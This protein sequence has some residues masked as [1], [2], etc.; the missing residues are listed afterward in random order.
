MTAQA[1]LPLNQRLGSRPEEPKLLWMVVLSL[2]L[3]GIAFGVFMGL[4]PT[5]SRNIYYSPVYSVDLVGLPPAGSSF[6]GSASKQTAGEQPK[7]T[8]TR[9]WKGPSALESQA[10]PQAQRAHPVLTIPAKEKELAPRRAEPE[11]RSAESGGAETPSG[12]TSGDSGASQGTSAPT[13]AADSS[14]QGVGSG[15]PGVPGG[16]PG[17]TGGG[18]MAD[19]RFR[20][21]YQLIYEKIYQAWTLPEYV[22]ERERS[23]EAIVVIK[24]QRD[25]KILS[26]VFETTSGNQ[27]FDISVMNAIK[28]ANPLPPLPDDFRDS[29]L[30]IGVRFIPQ[31]KGP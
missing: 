29:F 17:G 14:T 13:P 7:K 23:R 21:Y 8:D 31:Q 26:A 18:G 19:L 10:K 28:K 22:M 5:S 6:P 3:H 1:I 16:V 20:Q 30:E 12:G 25:G 15:P 24:V 9:L 2:L 11:S 4:P 27:Q